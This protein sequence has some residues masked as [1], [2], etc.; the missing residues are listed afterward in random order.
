MKRVA[1]VTLLL[2][3]MAMSV[4]AATEVQSVNAVGSIK[5]DIAAGELVLISYPF[6]ALEDYSL[7]T[8]IG[9]QMANGSVAHIWDSGA[10]TYQTVAKGRST[11]WSGATVAQGQGF[12]LQSTAVSGTQTVYIVGEVPAANNDSETTTVSIVNIADAV[13]Y[14]FPVDVLFTNTAIAQDASNGDTMHYWDRS[15][16]TWAT[17]TKGRSTGWGAANSLQLNAGEAFFYQPAGGADV[18]WTEIV[19]YDLNN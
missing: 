9:D 8:L 3:L 6:I 10:G 19:P 18:D 1:L 12:W 16:A 13:G 17:S 5:L 14:T 15:I 2:G 11:G 4:I 7:D